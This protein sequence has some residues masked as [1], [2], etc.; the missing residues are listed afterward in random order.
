MSVAAVCM[1]HDALNFVQQANALACVCVQGVLQNL[2]S[3]VGSA[4]SSMSS[5]AK[6]AVNRLTGDSNNGGLGPMP[7]STVR[8]QSLTCASGACV[9]LSGAP[10]GLPLHHNCC[11]RYQVVLSTVCC[12]YCNALHN[13][14]H[15][16]VCS[17]SAHTV[18]PAA[19]GTCLANRCISYLFIQSKD[20]FTNLLFLYL[21]SPFL[22]V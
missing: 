3:T 20:A 1:G 4:A 7:G 11:R 2:T 21:L 10:C 8:P 12:T 15:N 18:R 13:L 22:S 17:Q 6:N 5:S 19:C 14:V 9:A 16:M